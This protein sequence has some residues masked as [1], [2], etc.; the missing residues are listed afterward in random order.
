MPFSMVLIFKDCAT[1]I[2]S[3]NTLNHYAFQRR[4]NPGSANPIISLVQVRPP[5]TPP[6][7][8]IGEEITRDRITICIPRMAIPIRLAV[9]S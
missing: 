3:E 6:Y 4:P 5:I 2:R 9:L 7:T 1:E 8:S